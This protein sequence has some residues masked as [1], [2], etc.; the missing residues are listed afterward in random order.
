ML[1]N[2]KTRD[3][4]TTALTAAAAP[5]APAAAAAAAPA[6]ACAAASE[7]GLT[8]KQRGVERNENGLMF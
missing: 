8:S 1:G 4:K 7:I 6:A 3:R 5:A 2:R